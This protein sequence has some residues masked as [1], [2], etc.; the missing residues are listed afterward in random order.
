MAAVNLVLSLAL[1]AVAA[2]L[3]HRVVEHAMLVA[4]R[5]GRDAGAVA[6]RAVAG[7][8]LA[9]IAAFGVGFYVG[10]G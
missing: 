4:R 2:A 9:G 5:D 8:C 7:A 10:W 3:A 6:R 1:I